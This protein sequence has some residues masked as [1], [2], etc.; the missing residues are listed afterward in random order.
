MT[1]FGSIKRTLSSSFSYLTSYV[2]SATGSLFPQ[3]RRDES[4]IL[5]RELPD[6]LI[7]L[8]GTRVYNERSWNERRRPEILELFR[9]HVYGRSPARSVPTPSNITNLDEHALDGTAL[10]KE[11]IIRLVGKPYEH[12]MT[13]I[14]YLPNNRLKRGDRVPLFLGLNFF[15]NQTIP[16]DPGISISANCPPNTSIARGRPPAM[17]RCFKSSSWPVEFLLENGYGL[18]SI[19]YGD[20]VPDHS[21]ALGFGIHRWFL[22]NELIR[23]TPDSWGAIGGWAWGLSRAMDYLQSD[24]DVDSNKIVLIGHSRLGKAALWAGAQDERF[25]MVIA[26][27]SGCGG[28]ALSRRKI[29]ETVASINSSFP[30]WFCSNFKSYNENEA[31]LPVDQHELISLIA[32]RPV[33][34]ASAQLDF[35]ADP[36]WEF[37]GAKLASPV[38]QLF[39][40][41]G[42]P[43]DRPPAL[44]VP[45]MGTIGYHVRRGR[46]GIIIFDWTQFVKFA[47]KHLINR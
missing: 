21:D 40:K 37:L 16:E 14:L 36:E 44:D 41:A 45:I 17:N 13:L 27:E 31:R 25:A 23:Q 32:P 34:I 42:L 7:M 24:K 3:R 30:H 8:D 15:G 4:R 2:N 47:D 33:Y 10:R 19:Y 11:V 29:G 43:A 38:Y 22:E 1:R 35:D 12:L 18:A 20:I 26:N 39:G 5:I 46:H 9:M 28:A 6:P